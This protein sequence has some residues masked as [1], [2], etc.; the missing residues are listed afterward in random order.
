MTALAKYD[1]LEAIGRYLSESGEISVIIT[2]GDSSLVV[3]DSDETPLTHWPLVTLRRRDEGNAALTLTPDEGSRERLLIDD[4]QMIEAIRTVC[5]ELDAARPKPPPRWRRLVIGSACGLTAAALAL[6]ILPP[7]LTDRF[8]ESIPDAAERSMGAGMASQYAASVSSAK[9]PVF[10]SGTAGTK[11]LRRFEKRLRTAEDVDLITL[12]VIESPDPSIAAL[13]GGWI[14]LSS[15]VLRAFDSPEA[16]AG[17]L[18]IEIAHTKA[19]DPLRMTLDNL[20]LPGL[21]RVLRGVAKDSEL[22]EAFIAGQGQGYDPAIRTKAVHDASKLL[23]NVGLP[24]LPLGKYL[25]SVDQSA[26]ARS[27]MDADRVG[28]KPFNPALSDQDW[29]A[30]AGICD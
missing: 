23:G 3:M 12:K 8:V 25:L 14:V 13:P 6:F 18:A 27:V 19:G 1:R 15:G 17:I 10:C 9:L 7:M 4:P 5:E 11:A 24:T 28:K 29:V 30:L 21:T 16:L 2:F 20:G 26:L 22:A